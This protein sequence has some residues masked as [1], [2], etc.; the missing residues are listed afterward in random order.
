MAADVVGLVPAAG[1]ATRLGATPCSKE[2]F[3]VSYARDAEGHVRPVTASEPLLER[4]RRAGARQAYIVLRAGKWDI[5]SYLG[6]G[7]RFGVPLGYLMMRYPWGQPFTL[8]AAYPFVR[9]ATVL[10]GFPDILLEEED[11]YVRL[12]EQQR[13]SGADLVLGLFPAAWPEKSDMVEVS[14]SGEVLDIVIKPEATDLTETWLLAAWSPA[15]SAFL[16]EFVAR[17]LRDEVH[18]HPD[19]REYYV[20]DVMRAAVREG[21]SID[22]VRFAESGYIDIGTPDELFQAVRARV[23]VASSRAEPRRP[24]SARELPES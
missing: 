13:T 11:A 22:T 4:F 2:I 19:G 23:H 12:L 9:D 21:M 7:R 6:D 18:M 1:H 5:P 15:F 24:G 14:D 8:D 17:C 3:P 10:L 20:G 16:H